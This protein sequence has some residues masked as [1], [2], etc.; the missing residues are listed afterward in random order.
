[1]LC[2]K[3]NT[4]CRETGPKHI[5]HVNKMQRF[6]FF[7]VLHIVTTVFVRRIKLISEP[8]LMCVCV[9]VCGNV[10][11]FRNEGSGTVVL[12]TDFLTD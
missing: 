7:L 1:M 5:H 4:V 2:R 3:K 9:C 6:I 10:V 12:Y 11:L 8:T